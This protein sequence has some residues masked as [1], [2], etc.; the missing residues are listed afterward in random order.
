[1]TKTRYLLLCLTEECAEVQKEAMK[2]LRF[3]LDSSAEGNPTNLE[4]LAMEMIDLLATIQM[5]VKSTQQTNT[6]ASEE[7]ISKA[8]KHK[9]DKVE[10]YMEVSRKAGILDV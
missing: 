2:C 7:E 5:V 3:G 1:M 6:S 10:R 8:L 9:K 4:K